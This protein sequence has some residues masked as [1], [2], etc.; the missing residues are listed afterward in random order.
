MLLSTPGCVCQ[1]SRQKR[2]RAAS[3]QPSSFSQPVGSEQFGHLA[4]NHYSF[5]QQQCPCVTPQDELVEIPPFT[6]R[7][8]NPQFVCTAFPSCNPTSGA[9]VLPAWLSSWGCACRHSFPSTPG[10]MCVHA[11][12]S[13][14]GSHPECS[15]QTWPS[16]KTEKIRR[17][18]V[19]CDAL[20][21]HMPQLQ[22]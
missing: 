15:S 14:R 20:S 13:L 3:I 9:A 19:M 18:E 22:A 6:P 1:F 5:C 17:R 21:Q 4:D 8:L 2:V 7:C 16:R 10:E 12:P 11:A